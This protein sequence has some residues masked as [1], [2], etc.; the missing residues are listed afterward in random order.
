MSN[1]TASNPYDTLSIPIASQDIASRTLAPLFAGWMCNLIIWGMVSTSFFTHFGTSYYRRDNSKLKLLVWTVVI[2]AALSAAINCVQLVHYGV[3]QQRS[4]EHLFVSIVQNYDNVPSVLL[5]FIAALTQGFLTHR[6]SKLLVNNRI[7][8]L[9]FRSIMGFL[10]VASFL[11]GIGSAIIGFMYLSGTE[12]LALPLTVNI[13]LGVNMFISAAI[14]TSITLS[15]ILSLRKKIAGFNEETDGTI[16]RIM[17]LSAETGLP[18]TVVCVLGALLAVVFP[19][20]DITTVN[21]V[22][23][24]VFPLPSLYAFSLISTLAA[25]KTVSEGGSFPSNSGPHATTSIGGS[26]SQY[27]SGAKQGTRKGTFA[28]SVTV[29]QSTTAAVNVDLELYEMPVEHG[30]KGSHDELDGLPKVQWA[31]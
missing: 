4:Y 27:R 2:L 9:A 6:A 5:A 17:R 18:T 22:W 10:I 12:D 1:F 19:M 25:R 13:L 8:Y 11:A 30:E 14:D 31:S 20:E 3:S 16:R 7:A 29:H 26:A 23:A 21:I 28:Q 15:L 24:F